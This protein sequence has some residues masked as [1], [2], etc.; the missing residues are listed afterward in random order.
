M[1]TDYRSGGGSGRLTIVGTGP[2]ALDYLTPAARQA[3]EEATVV[4]GYRPYLEMI[5]DIL[6]NQRQLGSAMMQEVD[7]VAQ[8]LDSAGE[9]QTVA[10]VSGGDPGIYAMAGLV[11]EM[12]SKRETDVEIEVVAGLAALNSCAAQLGA[13]LMH[14]FCCISLSDLLTPW[15][16]IE[17]RL[18]AAAG[19]DFVIVIYNPRSKKR[20]WQLQRA[21]DIVRAHRKE[22]TPVGIVRAA[23]RPQQT[24]LL[25]TL[26]SFEVGPVDMQTTVIIGNS[27]TYVWNGKMITP[28]GYDRKYR[29][30]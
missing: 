22:E 2:G 8:A 30:D 21:C 18:D 19:A 23:T 20:D 27:R 17:K 16:L 7:R 15:D 14:D 3:I 5:A 4:V 13:P 11:Y 28:R 26:G 29:L 6:T 25:T 12:A 9:G 10:L 1:E 24:V